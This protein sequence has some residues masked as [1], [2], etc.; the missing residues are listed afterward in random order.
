MALKVAINGFGRIGRMI[1]RAFYERCA[2]TFEELEGLQGVVQVVAVNDIAPMDVNVHLFKYDSVHGVFRDT[3]TF[4]AQPDKNFPASSCGSLNL[5]YGPIALFREE[6]PAQLPWNDM[7]I[8]VVFECTGRMMAREKASRHL[9]AG[10]KRVLI[11]APSQDADMTVVYGVNHEQ[12]T[13]ETMI[14][15]N[16]SCTTNAA[17]PLISVLDEAVGFQ[18]GHLTTVHAY[19]AGQRILDGSHKDL[20]RARAAGVSIVPTTTGAT[21]TLECVMP[22]MKGKINAVAL[23]VPTPNVS[24]LDLTFLSSR[25]TDAEELNA[26]LER[27]AQDKMMGILGVCHEPLV[28]VDFNNSPLSATVDLL[29]TSVLEGRLCRVFTWYDNEWGFSHRMLDVAA[30]LQSLTKKKWL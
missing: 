19:T 18:S 2:Y 8:D 7:G 17:A 26:A 25:A 1:L 24:S 13:S 27:A 21:K 12:M 11:S 6:D 22:E 16:A 3:L 4:S 15:S 9:V 20:R 10:A 5:G 29:Q 23:R 14:L 30:Y 28:S